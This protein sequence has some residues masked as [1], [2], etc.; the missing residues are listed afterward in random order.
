MAKS[1]VTLVCASM[2]LT[3]VL[4][5]LTVHHSEPTDIWANQT[6]HLVMDVVAVVFMCCPIVRWLLEK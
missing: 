6:I 5:L 2:C 3:G 4:L 1:Q